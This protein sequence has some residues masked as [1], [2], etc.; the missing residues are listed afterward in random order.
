MVALAELCGDERRV[1]NVLRLVRSRGGCG[2]AVF[3]KPG[4]FIYGVSDNKTLRARVTIGNAQTG[5][6]KISLSNQL[7]TK[8]KGSSN[9]EV[10]LGHKVRGKQL[11][12]LVTVVDVNPSTNVTSARL[13][14]SGGAPSTFD[15][16][17]D[18]GGD[19]DTTVFTFLVDLQ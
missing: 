9:I 17:F 18:E 3:F 5:A 15:L 10:G 19:G 16:D 2:M 6:W 4:A 14:L 13:V 7:V 12:V 1:A 11:Q 8:G